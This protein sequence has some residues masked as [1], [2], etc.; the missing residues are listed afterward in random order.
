MAGYTHWAYF[1]SETQA[2]S[3]MADLA[4]CVLVLEDPDEHGV[5][6]LR[7]GQNVPS[8][9]PPGWRDEVVAAV[10]RHGGVYDGGEMAF[11]I[12]VT[13]KLVSIP[14]PALVPPDTDPEEGANRGAYLEEIL[15]SG[16]IG[17]ED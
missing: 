13:G 5:R 16:P 14:D 8:G 9:L 15:G 2:R 1:S 3:C 4:D 17:P 6:L 10:R 12:G 11:G 7:A